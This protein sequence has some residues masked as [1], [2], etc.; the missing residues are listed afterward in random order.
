M[1]DSSGP[2]IEQIWRYPVKS[3][4][5][6]QLRECGIDERGLIGDRLWAVTDRAT[7]KLGSGKSSRRFERFPGPALLEL[8]ARYPVE[9]RP[10]KVAPPVLV[11][12]DGTEVSVEDGGADRFLRGA[13]GVPTLHVDRETTVSHFDDGPVTLLGTATLRWVEENLPGTPVDA[14]R[15]RPNLVVRTREPFEEER[16]VG[17]NVRLGAAPDSAL[18][19]FEA[20][21]VRC[22]MTTAAQ[23]DL[24]PAPGMLKLLG[25]RADQPVR[26]AVLGR[27]VRPGRVRLGD[28]LVIES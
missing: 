4:R 23:A 14:R 15:F 2:L 3:L 24:P 5:G 6:E 13:S 19:A 20:V 18:I 7:G 9:P 10:D 26:L 28:R 16:W 8:A 1:D 21:L 12:R 17:R 27:A 25:T 11:T 22:V